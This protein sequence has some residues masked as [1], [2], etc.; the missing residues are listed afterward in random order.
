M[1][2]MSRNSIRQKPILASTNEMKSLRVKLWSRIVMYEGGFGTQY[3]AAQKFFTP[4]QG[5]DSNK[6]WQRYY[7]GHP[8]KPNQNTIS[9]VSKH[10]PGLE[11]WFHLPIWEMFTTTKYSE[12][13]LLILA[14]KIQDPVIL[15]KILYQHDLDTGYKIKSKK[16]GHTINYLAK[17]CNAEALG[18]L[19]ILLANLERIKS[20]QYKSSLLKGITKILLMKSFVFPIGESFSNFF[21]LFVKR[22][23]Y[24]WAPYE[25]DWKLTN[26]SWIIPKEKLTKLILSFDHY[27]SSNWRNLGEA[28]IYEIK[29]EDWLRRISITQ[30]LLFVIE[31]LIKTEVMEPSL[32]QNFIKN[33]KHF[34]YERIEFQQNQNQLLIF[35]TELLAPV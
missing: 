2:A 20:I 9:K 30:K 17:E 29:V 1:L 12:K 35:F 19:S 24:Q 7:F 31:I 34:Y 22:F 16:L 5:E 11:K 28:N 25:N 14:Y 26:Q 32:K 23:F 33:T 6:Q 4:N 15:N 18:A 13:E 21:L 8:I 10:F 27:I 3:R